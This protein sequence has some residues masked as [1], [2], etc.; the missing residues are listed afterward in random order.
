[1][2]ERSRD[3]RHR[4]VRHPLSVHSY[5][6]STATAGAAAAVAAL[7]GELL[8]GLAG[9]VIEIGAGSGLN[10]ARYP[11]QVAEVVAVEPDRRLRRLAGTAAL[12]AEVP[13]DVVPAHAEA[14]PM[15]SEAFDAAVSALAL[16]SVRDLRRSLRELRRVLRP[17]AELRFLEHGRAP[18]RAMV[19]AQR[20]LD[21]TVWPALCGGCHTGRDI[22]AELR[23]AGFEIGASRRL[24]MPEHGRLLPTSSWVLGVA[25][26]PAVADEGDR[27]PGTGGGA[28]PLPGRR[29]G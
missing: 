6:G 25:R 23:A 13:V 1:M 27:G 17:G 12:R 3:L 21:R 18:G 11:R 8:R 22:V 4:P 14:L 28:A 24:R 9:R 15:K 26:R 5:A 16:C 20:V 7:R 2:R 29:S 19:L 10:F